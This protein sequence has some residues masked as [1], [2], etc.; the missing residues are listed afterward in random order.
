MDKI[1]SKAQEIASLLKQEPLIEEFLKVKKIY[2]ND[3]YLLSLRQEI[4]KLKSE[5]K[6]EERQNLIK[7]YESHP[8]V[9]NY[10]FLLD[11]VNNFLF[12]I[13][14]ALE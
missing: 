14:N 13:K 5:N 12:E 10:Y 7:V 1:I 3:E 4:A 2:E 8:I 11:E 6:E 9:N